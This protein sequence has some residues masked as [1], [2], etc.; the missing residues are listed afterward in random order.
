MLICGV[1]WPTLRSP[2]PICTLAET[3]S[4]DESSPRLPTADDLH[5]RILI[6]KLLGACIVLI[7]L[8]LG[9]P[10]E[11]FSAQ[12]KIS[13]HTGL[14]DAS[15]SV[16]PAMHALRGQYSGRDFISY[17]GPLSQFIHG[18]WIASGPDDLAAVVRWNNSLSAA[19]TILMLWL[20]LATTGRRFRG[21]HRPTCCG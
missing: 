15:S 6:Q 12:H 18:A 3:S 19:I 10:Q 14:L 8:A 17:Y 2:A 13:V 5:S 20:V 11:V 21:G 7:G 4:T 16:E 1:D 9:L